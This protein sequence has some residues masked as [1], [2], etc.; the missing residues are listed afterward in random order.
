[1]FGRTNIRPVKNG[2]YTYSMLKG[3]G[4]GGSGY[5]VGYTFIRDALSLHDHGERHCLQSS[6]AV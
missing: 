5:V 4:G 6:I 2:L 3:G 1:M